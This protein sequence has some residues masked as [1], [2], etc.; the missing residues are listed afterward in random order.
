MLWLLAVTVRTVSLQGRTAVAVPV[1][2]T[3]L[4]G[5]GVTVICAVSQGVQPSERHDSGITLMDAV[6]AMTACKILW[7]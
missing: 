5:T 7:K 6:P 3:S 1:I 4:R 2:V